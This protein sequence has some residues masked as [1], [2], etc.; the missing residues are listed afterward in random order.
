[1][2]LK[3]KYFDKNMDKLRQDEKG[4]WIDLRVANG[5]VVVNQEQFIKNGF[6]VSA[7]NNWVDGK[8]WF[9]EGN[10][11]ICRLGVAIELPV[12]KKAN[13]Y[14]RSST[15]ATY[16]LLLTNAVGCIDNKYKGDNDEWLAVFYATRDGFIEKYDRLCQFDVVDRMSV[17]FEEVDQLGLESRG[18]YGTT[19][20]N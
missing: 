3:I 15:F 4:D 5:A 9:N 8:L 20:R 1:M 11:I 19:G 7:K 16:G 14:P 17:Q 6:A 18:G 12:D 2:D 13:I 10:V